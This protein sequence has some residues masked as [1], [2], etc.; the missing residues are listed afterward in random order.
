MIVLNQ[1]TLSLR[2]TERLK[3]IRIVNC[4]V[5][6]CEESVI[7]TDHLRVAGNLHSRNYKKTIL[8]SSLLRELNHH[9][10][11]H[12]DAFLI[13]RLVYQIIVYCLNILL[14][15]IFEIFH[16]GRLMSSVL[17]VFSHCHNVETVKPCFLYSIFRSYTTIR[18]DGVGVKIRLVDIVAIYLREDDF[19]AAASCCSERMSVDIL[20]STVKISKLCR[21]THSCY[22]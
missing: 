19:M 17:D 14:F 7:M 13:C 22:K 2:I 16:K 9:I 11:I 6:R 10:K 5:V 8:S 1:S 15:I 3:R 20:V 18:K 21:S 12:L 4:I